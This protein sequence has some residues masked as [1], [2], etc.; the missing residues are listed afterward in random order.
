MKLSGSPSCA[1]R[2]VISRP[3][4]I[5]LSASGMPASD[6]MR[7]FFGIS[8]NR[9]SI[10]F[11]PMAASICST[12]SGV[13]GMNGM[14]ALRG[15]VGL[16]FGGAQQALRRAI[17]FQAGNPATAIGF[18]IDELGLTAERAV[19]L[20]DGARDRRVHVGGGLH[21]FDH[22]ERIADLQRLARLRHVDEH[23][24]T[25]RTLRVIGDAHFDVAV[26][27]GAHPLVRLGVLE[28]GGNVAH[29]K[30]SVWNSQA[31][32]TWPLRTKGALTTRALSS[33]PRMSTCTVA[34]A[35]RGTRASAMDF[36]IVGENV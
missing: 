34:P 24:V 20:D 2:A 22:R 1:A 32:R 12:S 19:A 26:G 17:R 14:S 13:W 5:S 31:T 6:S 15:Q 33:L 25:E 30:C 29:G 23:Q 7:R 3:I 11:A 36:S 16:V 35:S 27:Q 28:I 21:R 8:S 4:C 10:F 18:G 9:S